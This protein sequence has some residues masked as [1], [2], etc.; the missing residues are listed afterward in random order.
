MDE[1]V[2]T[3]LARWP[4]VPDVYRWLVLDERGRYRLR[5]ADYAASGGF[6]VIGNPAITDFIGRNYQ[7]DA[8]GR[9]YFQN[10]PQRVFVRLNLTPWIYRCTSDHAPL[11]HTGRAATHIEGLWIDDLSR[12]VMLTD[13]GPG[14]VD[15]RDLDQI[16]TALTDS[17]GRPID[18]AGL[19]AWLARPAT[20][21][22]LFSWGGSRH[23]VQP[24]RHRELE[25]RFGFVAD[26]ASP[27][28]GC[29]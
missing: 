25:S 23:A 2:R 24:I 28:P 15:D 1:S 22:L 20:G 16:V 21:S 12:P 8:R 7:S 6:E 3:A 27:A 11:T 17:D 4:D 14:A 29:A 19:A 5:A 13:I 9:W 10:G 26:P 18:E